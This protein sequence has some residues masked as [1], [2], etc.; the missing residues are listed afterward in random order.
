MRGDKMPNISKKIKR[1]YFFPIA[2]C[3]VAVGLFVAYKTIAISY[4]EHELSAVIVGTIERRGQ[5]YELKEGVLYKG[6]RE[7][8]FFEKSAI[9]PMA[10]QG[11]LARTDPVFSLEG[12]DLVAFERA[13]GLFSTVNKNIV[14]DKGGRNVFNEVQMYPERFLSSI[15]E[16]ERFRRAFVT[17]PSDVSYNAYQ[18]ALR[19]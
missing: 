19:N 16:A 17:R 8:S 13:R 6:G 7:A 11:V 12:T 5:T 4:F 1:L 9:L 15:A 2:A 10:Y 3:M 14:L 18:R